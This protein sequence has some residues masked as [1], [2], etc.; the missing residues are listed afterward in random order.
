MNNINIKCSMI[1]IIHHRINEIGKLVKCII[2][3]YYTN[4]PILL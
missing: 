4:F 2:I 3:M 1:E